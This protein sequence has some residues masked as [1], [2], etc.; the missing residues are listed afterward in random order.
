MFRFTLC[1]GTLFLFA[2]LGQCADKRPTAAPVGTWILRT[3]DGGHFIVLTIS[4]KGSLAW[5]ADTV[6]A[7]SG[8]MT[9]ADFAVSD[10]NVLYGFMS[11]LLHNN[12]E[13]PLEGRLIPFCF[14]FKLDGEYPRVIE[15]KGP[16]DEDGERVLCGK[17]E[18]SRYTR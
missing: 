2:D 17:Y 12:E 5:K 3:E 4:E 10:D 8:E 13:K 11:S 15:V 6:G 16:F 7:G 1:L 9:A 18:R 14:S